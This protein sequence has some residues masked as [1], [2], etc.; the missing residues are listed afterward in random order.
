MSAVMSS[1]GRQFEAALQA[2]RAGRPDE[3]ARLLEGVLRADPGSLA[4]LHLYGL[5]L[6]EL[7]DFAG[8]EQSLRAAIAIDK[9]KPGLHAALGA[10]MQ[11]TGR[12]A[13]AEKAYRA[14]LAIDRRH[15][16]TAH[17]LAELLV[18]LSRPTEA[19]QV[20]APITASASAPAEVLVLQ[21][22]AL[23]QLGRLEEALEVNHRAIAAGGPLMELEL[24]GT[25][26]DLGRYEEAAAAA[27]R[28]LAA[29][30]HPAAYIV[31]GRTEQDLG[32]LDEAEA[33]YRKALTFVPLDATAHQHLADLLWARTADPERAGRALDSVLA[34]RPTGPLIALKA[35]LLTRAGKPGEAD[36]LMAEAAARAPNDPLILAAAATA[37][38]HAGQADRA[39]DYAERAHAIVPSVPR[40]RAL[41][42]EACLAAGE[43][44]RAE[45]VAASLRREQPLNQQYIALEASA[46][47]ILGDPRYRELYDYEGLVGAYRLPTPEGWASL[48]AFLA[49]LAATLKGMHA[50]RGDPLDQ[51]LRNGTQTEQ[52]LAL[53]PDP[54]LRA[55]FKAADAP[56]A[57]HLRKMGKGSDPARARNGA[58]HRVKAAWSVRL[59]PNGF[60]VDHL[61]PDGWLSSAFYV[62][63]P[64]AVDRGR[65]GWIKFG[66]PGAPTRPP[67]EAEHFIKPEPGLLVLFPSYM[68][69]GTVPFSGEETRLTMAFDIVPGR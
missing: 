23:K 6:T 40:I 52:N 32:R 34:Q 62:E 20:L 5:A 65:E 63:L 44:K 50:M 67:L 56:I 43:A 1:L 12:A 54:V 13:E 8:A 9:K 45:E 53:S 2:M 4:A 29:G 49:D 21:A 15:V 26:R 38:A 33:A 51:S 59:A 19:L 31:H 48:E 17:G 42:A 3:T 35:R 41:L 14:G 18:S 66:Q 25:L 58:G 39:L 69:H 16:Q 61:H 36:A 7:G 55:F 30:D 64:G 10:V 27:R 57:E 37:A 22:I 46:W 68:W 60:H 24:A 11:R 47:R 28:A